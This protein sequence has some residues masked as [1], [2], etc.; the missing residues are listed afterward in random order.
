MA[1]TT[2]CRVPASSIR[3]EMW[4]HALTEAFWAGERRLRIEPPIRSP[5]GRTAR[6]GTCLGS[7]VRARHSG[8]QDSPE[9]S[10]AAG[11]H[12]LQRSPLPCLGGRTQGVAS[13]A[14]LTRVLNARARNRDWSDWRKG[15]GRWFSGSYASV[16]ARWMRGRS[17]AS[18]RCRPIDCRS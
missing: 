4:R 9:A 3:V 14:F 12:R 5:I 2:R 11:R 16:W 18:K 13:F 7:A 6:I 1:G 17:H 10:V 8:Q 15:N